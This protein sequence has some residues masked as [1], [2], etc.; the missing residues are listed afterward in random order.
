MN[1]KSF[2]TVAVATEYT[3]KTS[4][5]NFDFRFAFYDLDRKNLSDISQKSKTENSLRGMVSMVSMS[6]SK[7]VGPG[8]SP[9]TPA[10]KFF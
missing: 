7:T 10:R 4:S 6:V 1:L 2:V 3:E 8:S 9:G 5:L